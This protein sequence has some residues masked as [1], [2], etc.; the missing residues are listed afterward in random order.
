MIPYTIRLA[1]IADLPALRSIWQEYV[2]TMTDDKEGYYPRNVIGSLDDWTRSVAMALAK[3]PATSFV[4]LAEH[5]G[6]LLAFLL[7]EHQH[8]L[9]GEPHEIAYCHHL[10]VRPSAQGHGIGPALSEVYCEHALAQGLT[11]CEASY[12]PGTTWVASHPYDWHIVAGHM[13]IG[14]L[15]AHFDKRRAAHA[16]AAERANGHDRDVPLVSEEQ[17][18]RVNKEEE[19]DG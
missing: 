8:R 18:E 9:I 17:P 15:L 19:S 1:T 4:F 7:W 16:L 12:F 14:R 3:V 10:Y 11:E 6:E 5:A 2:H 13:P